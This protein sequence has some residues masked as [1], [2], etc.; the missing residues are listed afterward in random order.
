MNFLSDPWTKSQQKQLEAALSLINASSN[1]E[2][3]STR[4]SEEDLIRYWNAIAKKVT[5]KGAAQCLNQ[6]QMLRQKLRELR[7]N[8]SKSRKVS[9]AIPSQ[10]LQQ[11]ESPNSSVNKEMTSNKRETTTIIKASLKTAIKTVIK[12]TSTATT[13]TITKTSTKEPQSEEKSINNAKEETTSPIPPTIWTKQEYEQLENALKEFQFVQDKRE[14]WRLIASKVPT[15]KAS[16]C[17]MKYKEMRKALMKES[18][19]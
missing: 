5:G 12:T 8:R 9:K 14:K 13:E 6:Y 18:S 7:K 19:K 11:N 16:Q 4:N 17:L 15:R 2:I 1:F 3:D 10:I